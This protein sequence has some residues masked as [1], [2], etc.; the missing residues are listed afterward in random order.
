MSSSRS[1][2]TFLKFTKF[3]SRDDG[4]I[5]FQLVIK[6]DTVRQPALDPRL[7]VRTDRRTRECDRIR[8]F[9]PFGGIPPPESTGHARQ[10]GIDDLA[11]TA[12]LTQ[13]TGRACN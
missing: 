5:S 4:E 11:D 7:L 10:L 12:R 2:D 9:P 13:P 8:P 6:H 3:L 1:T